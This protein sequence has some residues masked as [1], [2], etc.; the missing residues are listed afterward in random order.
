MVFAP[1]LVFVHAGVLLTRHGVLV[2]PGRTHAGKSTLVKALVDLG[3]RYCSD[4]Y[5]IIDQAG[6]VQPFQ[7]ALHQRGEPDTHIPARQ[8]GWSPQLQSEPVGAVIVTAYSPEASW[9]PAPMTRGEATMRMME[10][11]V[12]TLAAPR[13]TISHLASAVRT[14]RCSQSPRGEASETAARIMDW[15]D[16]E[17]ETSW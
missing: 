3:A 8:L 9:S 14:A 4:E 12:G 1:A 7:R 16:G 5:A 17:A 13:R 6:R 10:N 11:T 15:L 2:L